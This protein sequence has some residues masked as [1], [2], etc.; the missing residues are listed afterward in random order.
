LLIGLD[1]L[2]VTSAFPLVCVSVGDN[3]LTS[4]PDSYVADLGPTGTKKALRLLAALPP[5]LFTTFFRGITFLFA[6]T[7]M[8]GQRIASICCRTH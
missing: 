4:V 7:G 2:Q 6:L 8:C 5:L 1:W 3:L